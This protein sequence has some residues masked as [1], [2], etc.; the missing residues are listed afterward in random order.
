[1]KQC[2][3]DLKLLEQ[4]EDGVH[5]IMFPAIY[6]LEKFSESIGKN[7]SGNNHV[8][9]DVKQWNIRR[10][11]KDAKVILK[12]LT[13]GFEIEDDLQRSIDR[14]EESMEILIDIYDRI[15][16]YK[17]SSILA[18]YISSIAS[19]TLSSE[20]D[21]DENYENDIRDLETITKS[22]LILERYE[23]AIK[24]YK[25]TY[26]PYSSAEF[27]EFDIPDN[28][29]N[30]NINIT[31]LVGNAVEGLNELEKRI[32]EKESTHIN[33]DN[34]MINAEKISFY[35]W[36]DKKLINKLFDGQEIL[37]K[38]DIVNGIDENA[39][40][41]N[42]IGIQFKL[43]NTCNESEFQIALNKFGITLKM[44]GN[45]YYRCGGKVYYFSMDNTIE[46]YHSF[47]KGVEHKHKESNDSLEK[48]RK[49]PAFLSPY[50][51]WGIK[52]EHGNFSEIKKY[53][54]QVIYFELFGNGKYL[55]KGQ[56][57]DEICSADVDK[58]Y[59]SY[60]L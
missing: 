58:F 28:L 54:D 41:F 22:N 16:S 39:V 56:H 26:F 38:A 6:K 36:H 21:G 49:L 27:N 50:T 52:M 44:L 18:T 31:L 15:D 34:F 4:M 9:I 59:R 35:Q 8:Q 53:E 60:V 19:S 42:D 7:L 32:E 33:Q 25:Q 10:T 46:I 2:D 13:K 43:K 57:E 29:Q 3:E 30:K 40:K 1:M 45:N 12:K 51:L 23:G 55:K 37:V 17:D 24:A 14:M 20:L 5:E 47:E 48:I 11:F